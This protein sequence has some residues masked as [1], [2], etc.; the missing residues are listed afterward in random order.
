VEFA[1][2]YQFPDVVLGLSGRDI[3][4]SRDIVEVDAGFA[5]DTVT[6]P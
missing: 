4:F 1:R 2:T 5:V 3:E 6:N